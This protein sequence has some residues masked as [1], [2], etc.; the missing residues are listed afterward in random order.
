M[1]IS[2]LRGL[3]AIT[4]GRP[5]R[6][7]ERCEQA[8]AGGIVMLQYRDLT[9]DAGR[10]REEASALARLCSSYGVPLIV[11]HDVALARA[12]GAQG[13]HLSQADGDPAAAR[14]LLGA[15][16]IVGVSCYADAGLA[17]RAVS[18]GASYVSFGAFFASPT[19]P[20]AGSAP[21][22][23]LGETAGLGVP[24][25]AIGGITPNNGRSLVAAGVELIASVSA[26]FAA[27][28]PRAAAAAM[29][30]LFTD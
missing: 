21:P 8:L 18:T 13:V 11:D 14:D 17:R 1:D 23:L 12:V 24:R 29:A 5:S 27:D 6:L 16:T 2:S 15:G 7:V 22:G 19:K 10:R 30:A 25:V 9:D 3:Y 26:I 20:G 4:D 28:D